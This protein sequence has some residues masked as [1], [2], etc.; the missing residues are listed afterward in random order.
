[1]ATAMRPPDDDA[2][3][4]SAT[5]RLL[6][7]VR[8][9]DWI[10]RL[11]VAATICWALFAMFAGM[12]VAVLMMAPRLASLLE[13]IYGQYLAFGRLRP[14]H[15]SAAVFAFAGNA[16]FAGIYYSTQ[17]LCQCRIWSDALALG[18]FLCWQAI[19]LV[20]L[21]T[22]PLG[23]TQGRPLAEHQWPIDLALLVAWVGMFGINFLLTLRQRRQ[24]QLYVSLWFYLATLFAFAVLFLVNSLVI[25]LGWWQSKPLHAGAVDAL[26]QWWYGDNAIALL[27]TLPFLGLMYYFVPKAAERPVYSYKLAIV[28]FWALLLLHL[29]AGPHQVHFSALPAWL[30]TMALLAGVMLWMPAWGAAFN[31]LMTLRAAPQRLASDPV[32][33]FFLVALVSYAVVTL[34][35]PLLGITRLNAVTQYS[36]WTI[37]H[38]H[39]GA[40]GFSGMLCFGMLYWLLP[41]LMRTSLWSQRLATWHF[42]LATIG[43]LLFVLP[44]Y[45]AG[46]TQGV[47]LLRIDE[48][49][50]LIYPTFNETIERI[51]RWWHWRALGGLFYL[52][53]A[54]TLAINYVMT[55]ARRSKPREDLVDWAP[56]VI[57][58]VEP[59]RPA[60]SALAD[61]P[62]LEVAKRAEIW[63]RLAW[64]RRWERMPSRMTCVISAALLLVMLSTLLPMVMVR[65]NVPRIDSVRPYTPLELAGRE[66]YVT[67]GCVYCH[68]QMVRPL[69]AETL[70]D[71][72]FSQPGESIHDFPALWGSR[73]IGGDLAR[74]GG[75]HPSLWHWDH[76]QRPRSVVPG[77]L[78]PAYE[79]LLETPL[80]F[81]KITE[82]VRVAQRLG[83]PY[84]EPLDE[85]AEIARAQAERIG[86][87]IVSQGGPVW[88]G[89]LMVIETQ[90]IALI[91]YLQRLG[92]DLNRPA[93]ATPGDDADGQDSAVQSPTDGPATT[94]A[95]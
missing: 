46:L 89:D 45:V 73:R 10:T 91:A 1:M 48:L 44:L 49:G 86:A 39:L 71:G 56:A 36:D 59:T 87:D 27:L 19:I 54:V 37:A 23:I 42:W 80:D 52:G 84:D 22:V 30:G 79:H 7:P 41:R 3:A 26:L 95:P 35:G 29:W 65:G 58:R 62:V 32:P 8:Y 55:W 5:D 13:P 90:A 83:V 34:Q 15:T 2:A 68:T 61:S 20:A 67:E 12:L 18:H 17:R 63:S 31:G 75:R 40:M 50:G 16:I 28:S 64:H 77:S 6:Q 66:I 53:G 51:S 11:F 47:M 33:K 74:E 81:E 9:N 57:E 38:A 43:V 78:M 85:V 70:R 92:V 88:H 60:V 14:L 94:D 25:P 21:V 72:D 93:D 82:L 76:L 69:V 4:D 24:R